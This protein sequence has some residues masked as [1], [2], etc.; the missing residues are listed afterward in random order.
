MRRYLREHG[1]RQ[2]AADFLTALDSGP[3]G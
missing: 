1:G 2:W 3:G